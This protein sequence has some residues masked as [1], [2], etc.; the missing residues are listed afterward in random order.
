L[1]PFVGIPFSA[2]PLPV[3]YTGGEEGSIQGG[4]GSGG[5]SYDEEY[6]A[7]GTTWT[8]S[9]TSI[10]CHTTTAELAAVLLTVPLRRRGQQQRERPQ[11]VIVVGPACVSPKCA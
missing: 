4:S 6:S 1:R 5:S 3:R 8:Y 2:C 10:V 9:D 11:R 7:M